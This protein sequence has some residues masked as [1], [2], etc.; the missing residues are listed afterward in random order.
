MSAPRFVIAVLASALAFAGC[1]SRSSGT[2]GVSAHAGANAGAASV[3]VGSGIS[4]DRVRVLVSQ[5]KLEG[6]M[7]DGNMPMPMPM[8]A[9]DD[10]GGDGGEGEDDGGVKIGPL[11]ADVS[12]GALSAAVTKVFDADVPDGSY[13][14]LKITVGPVTGAAEGSPVAAMGTSS[15]IVDGTRTPQ[16]ATSGTP[17]SFTTSLQ[18]SQKTETKLVVDHAGKSSNVTLVLD[19]AKWFTAGDGST[20]DPTVD[21]NRAAIEANILAN[22]RVERDDDEDGMDDDHEGD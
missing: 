10:G 3:D 6:G 20:L 1:S 18:A 4:V 2:L 13:D 15:I 19:V 5:L 9:A 12:G 22:L 8:M 21:A 14:E 7:G 17:F 16:G 11:V